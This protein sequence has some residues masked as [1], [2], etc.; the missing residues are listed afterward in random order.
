[1]ELALGGYDRAQRGRWDEAS[2]DFDRAIELSGGSPTLGTQIV[3]WR[4]TPGSGL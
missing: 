3:L 4:R 1:M 2:R